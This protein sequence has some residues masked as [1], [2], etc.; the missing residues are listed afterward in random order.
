MLDRDRVGA[1]ARAALDRRDLRGREGDARRRDGAASDLVPALDLVE[2][3]GD[4]ITD[5]EHEA[6]HVLSRSAPQLRDASWLEP[7]RVDQVPPM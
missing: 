2:P 1:G 4:W 5:K 7:S 3:T 6:V